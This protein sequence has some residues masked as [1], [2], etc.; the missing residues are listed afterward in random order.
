[1]AIDKSKLTHQ[2]DGLPGIARREIYEYEDIVYTEMYDDISGE[3]IS[4]DVQMFNGVSVCKVYKDGSISFKLPTGI[5]YDHR[6][7][8]WLIKDIQRLDDFLSVAVEKY[9]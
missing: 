1:M 5:A 2:S 6:S 9:H 8:M 4:G 7:L 3:L